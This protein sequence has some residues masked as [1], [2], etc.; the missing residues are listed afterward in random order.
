MM[1]KL[2]LATLFILQLSILP[3][4]GAETVLIDRVTSAEAEE[5]NIEIPADVI[6]III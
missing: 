4:W 5:L 6:E 1:R 2:L 3:S